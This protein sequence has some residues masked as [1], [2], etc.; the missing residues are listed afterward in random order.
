MNDTEN[1]LGDLGNRE[2]GIVREQQAIVVA[3]PTQKGQQREM[4]FILHP[5]KDDKLEYRD[6]RSG[7]IMTNN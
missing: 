4:V 3:V 2:L 1:I 6:L 7:G 5:M